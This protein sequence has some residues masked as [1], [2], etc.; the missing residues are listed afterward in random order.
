MQ[1]R[2]AS[3]C[4]SQLL[5]RGSAPGKNLL[6]F[7]YSQLQI[8]LTAGAVPAGPSAVLPSLRGS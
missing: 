4:H 5:G 2:E 6:S 7:R 1:H 8:L 3:K